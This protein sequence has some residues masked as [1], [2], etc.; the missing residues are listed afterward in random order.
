MN[1]AVIQNLISKALAKQDTFA[2]IVVTLTKEGVESYHVDFL[3][4]ESRL[5][6]TSGNLC[7]PAPRWCTT[8]SPLNFPRRRSNASIREFK[9]DKRV[10]PTS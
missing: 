1:H 7:W 9:Q 10:I 2:E 5:Y 3:R 4:N 8:G 6:A